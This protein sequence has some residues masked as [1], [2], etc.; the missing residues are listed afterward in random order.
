MLIDTHCHIDRFADPDAIVSN[1]DEAKVFTVAVTHLPSHFQRAADALANSRYVRPALGLHPLAIKTGLSQLQDFRTCFQNS[2]FI[3]E[4]GLDYSAVG[5]ETKEI[6]LRVFREIVDYLA[7][8]PKVTT[9]H[10]KESAS[11]VISVLIEHRVTDVILHWFS[12][13]TSILRHAAQAGFYFSINSAM[14]STK[15]GR[16]VLELVP[17]SRILTET[18]GPYIKIGGNPACPLGVAEIVESIGQ[19]WG[20][21]K[22]EAESIIE[23][24]F[25][26][27]CKRIS[28]ELPG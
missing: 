20:C 1:C 18:D 22:V 9:I 26:T 5:L 2:Q 19:Y 14:L 28:V 12:D 23:T 6:Q 8:N 3:G 7:D 11:E 10:T 4:I 13:S 27:L 21:S 15:S 24:N 17:K 25:R 16:K